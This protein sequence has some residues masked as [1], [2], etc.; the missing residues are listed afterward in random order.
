[1][2]PAYH[3]AREPRREHPFLNRRIMQLL[4][5]L[6]IMG[7][8]YTGL[9]RKNLNRLKHRETIIV[10]IH[11]VATTICRLLLT[12]TPVQVRH[13]PCP[14]PLPEQA[15]WLREHPDQWHPV[16]QK[17]DAL[18]SIRTLWPADPLP[19]FIRP[20]APR[21][22]EIDMT[23]DGYELWLDNAVLETQQGSHHFS[24]YAWLNYEAFRTMTRK[25]AEQLQRLYPQ[26]SRKIGQNLK[27]VD[28]QLWETINQIRDEADRL[29][30]NTP[31]RIRIG[32][33]ASDAEYILALLGSRLDMLHLSADQHAAVTIIMLPRTGTNQKVGSDSA[34]KV[35]YDRV[36]SASQADPKKILERLTKN[37]TNVLEALRRVQ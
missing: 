11:P 1:M 15:K 29:L 6:I 12:G 9:S 16:A 19:R 7:V 36:D 4:G 18:T 5:L 26:W 3:S 32:I 17:A 22:V 23:G 33:T 2:S 30:N 13:I 37:Y 10:S 25:T 20:I 8:I 27:I 34:I 14:L 35:V 28:N 21:T 24:P 31:N